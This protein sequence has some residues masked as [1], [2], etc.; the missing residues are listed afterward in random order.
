MENKEKIEILEKIGKEI[1]VLARNE[2]N[3]KAQIDLLEA[4]IKVEN[5]RVK[6]GL[7]DKVS[8]TK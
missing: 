5:L 4:V 2:L 8:E 7:I 3:P 6:Y 1:S